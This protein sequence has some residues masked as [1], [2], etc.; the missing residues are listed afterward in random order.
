MILEGLLQQLP[1]FLELER[2]RYFFHLAT[3]ADGT[4]TAG[5]IDWGSGNV[6]WPYFAEGVHPAQA[7]LGLMQ[8]LQLRQTLNAPS[9]PDEA[10]C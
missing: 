9:G 4:W 5:Y 7:L 6:P 1:P 8:T 10:V 2:V 3:A